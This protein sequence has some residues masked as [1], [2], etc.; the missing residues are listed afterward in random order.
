MSDIFYLAGLTCLASVGE[1]APS[2]TEALSARVG[3][4]TQGAPTHSEKGRGK[5]VRIVRA[6]DLE[7][8]GQ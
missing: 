7:G 1:K 4:D 3:G 6:C 8:G 2:L 5:R